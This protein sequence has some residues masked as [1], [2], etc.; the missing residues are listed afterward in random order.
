MAHVNNNNSYS[1]SEH[2]QQQDL[3]GHDT[4]NCLLSPYDKSL[5]P[6]MS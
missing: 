3:V 1:D 5:S 2:L 4:S 6:S